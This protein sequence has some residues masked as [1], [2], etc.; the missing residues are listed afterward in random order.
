MSLE[1]S[2]IRVVPGLQATAVMGRGLSLIPKKLG[3]GIKS[4]KKMI[5]GFADIIIGTALIKP[6]A[7][8]AARL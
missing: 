7:N 2:I 3:S 8:I 1:G 4:S 6:T 5:K